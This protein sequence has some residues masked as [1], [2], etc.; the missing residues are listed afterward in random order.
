VFVL[1][2]GAVGASTGA[3]FELAELMPVVDDGDVM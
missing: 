2:W 1:A 3:E